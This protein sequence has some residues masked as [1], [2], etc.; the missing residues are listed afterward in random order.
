VHRA[1][2]PS[3]TSTA[4]VPRFFIYIFSTAGRVE[5]NILIMVK[6]YFKFI[7]ALIFAT[8]V[9]AQ[10]IPSYV[11]KDGLVGYWPFN[12]NANDE[13]G[14][15]NHGTVNGATLTTDRNGKANSAYSFDD[16]KNYITISTSKSLI[17]DKQFSISIWFKR[18]NT[19]NNDRI[20]SFEKAGS[21]DGYQFR[22]AIDVNSIDNNK[23]YFMGASN[24]VNNSTGWTN[25]T[26][27][28]LKSKNTIISSTWNNVT[29]IRNNSNFSLYLNGN[30]QST[31]QSIQVIDFLLNKNNI[32]L[33]AVISNQTYVDFF[34]GNLDD[35]AIYNRALSDQE[36]KL[37]YEG[38]NVTA[39][40][41]P[42]GNTTFCQG[43][44]V[45]LNANFESNHNYQW[46]NND[47]LINGATKN[48]FFA[49]TE[50]KYTVKI[51]NGT[52]EAKS[53]PVNITV[54]PLPNATIT[55]TGNPAS[56]CEGNSLVLKA[57]GGTSYKWNSGETTNEITVTTGGA[58][59]AEVTNELGCKKVVWVD[60]RINTNPKVSIDNLKSIIFKNEGKIQLFAT[61]KGGAFSGEGIE[62]DY[63]NP[64]KSSLGKKYLS[65]KYKDA[66]GCT[67]V[68]NANVIVVDSIGNV[69]NITKYDT[70]K[71]TETI[72][73]TIKVKESTYDTLKI[74]VQLTT[75]IKAGQI[76][77]MNVYPNPT[78]D[79]VVIETSDVTALNGYSYKMVD[80]QG[81]QVYKELVTKSK[82]E[83]SLKSIGAKG[84]YILHI[85]DEKGVSIENK[86]IVLE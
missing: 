39:T 4:T 43:G 31:S 59:Y 86:K 60:V 67:G 52:C 74:K 5:T 20:F 83:I 46:Y 35:I 16:L 19:N 12:G 75:G 6:N 10:N 2:T 30:I 63:F 65:Y 80:L 9:M 79:V 61:P 76:A 51:Y 34:N 25:N 11:P 56:I 1:S 78:S 48:T 18:N 7:V 8:N 15:G 58:H 54:N 23:V 62:N 55:P 3:S 33:G 28:T 13:S 81:K 70:V 21:P 26:G 24:N 85:L 69:C 49:N 66:N 77:S 42:Q 38:C 64:S 32:T 71:V 73:D 45:I 84:V 47:Q 17:F 82:T 37:L 68:A 27:Y 44:S 40:I 22:F 41:T 53:D 14:N 72:Y 50:G 29:L 36:I 57:S